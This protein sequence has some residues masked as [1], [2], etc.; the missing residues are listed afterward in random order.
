MCTLTDLLC[1]RTSCRT[2]VHT[3]ISYVV[4]HLAGH[5][6]THQI[7]YVVE[8]LAGHVYTHQI[9]YV[10]EHLAGHVLMVPGWT[11]VEARMCMD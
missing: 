1:S 8:H 4:E 9:S 5:V 10:V 3:Q 6:Y 11:I 7:S 2:C